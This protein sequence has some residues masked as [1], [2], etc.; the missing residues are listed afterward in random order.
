MLVSF[1][2]TGD[3]DTV[4]MVQSQR[5]HGEALRVAAV[6][7]S[8]EQVLKTDYL[9]LFWSLRITESITPQRGCRFP[10]YP[11]SHLPDLW[12][13]QP[14]AHYL[15]L[16]RNFFCGQLERWSVSQLKTDMK[17]YMLIYAQT[18]SGGVCID[19][20]T[21]RVSGS[22]EGHGGKPVLLNPFVPLGCLPTY[23]HYSFK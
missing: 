22:L 13:I 23:K 15:S 5:P 12:T 6:V 14:P 2:V 1:F 16:P 4:F 10:H 7:D 20:V 3:K 8:I 17:T 9:L 18:V 11:S 19:R 21:A